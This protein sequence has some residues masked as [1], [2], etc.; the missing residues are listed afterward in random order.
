MAKKI[1]ISIPMRGKEQYE[2]VKGMERLFKLASAYLGED[3]EMINSLEPVKPEELQSDD[4]VDVAP[5]YLGAS[6]KLLSQADLVMF[7][8]YWT[9]AEECRIEKQVCDT[10]RIK[11]I[12]EPELLGTFKAPLSYNL[13]TESDY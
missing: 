12:V 1:F 5:L 4:I 7:D 8:K 6:I 13:E 10:Y 9:Q 2:I 11:H 3:C